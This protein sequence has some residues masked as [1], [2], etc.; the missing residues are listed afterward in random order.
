MGRRRITQ[1]VA[2]VFVV[3]SLASFG[4]LGPSPLL[5]SVSAKLA[6]VHA[7]LAQTVVVLQRAEGAATRLDATV[8]AAETEVQAAQHSCASGLGSLLGSLVPEVSQ[9]CNG[10]SPIA[11][12]VA[13]GAGELRRVRTRLVTFTAAARRAEL[14]AARAQA[15]VRDARIVATAILILE[16]AW[17]G[18]L[19]AERLW[20]PT[21]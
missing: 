9:L 18:L 11:A 5:G 6:Q 3:A 4:L 13:G 12:G 16:L 19:A 14:E 20:P 1:V 8:R 7:K 21:P 2:V 15:D 17:L 10:L